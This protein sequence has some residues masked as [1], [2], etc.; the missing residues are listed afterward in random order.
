[1]QEP[2]DNQEPDDNQEP[3]D[4]QGSGENQ[5]SG[6]PEWYRIRDIGRIDSP[7]LVVY[8]A[9]VRENIR[10][11]IAMVGGDLSRLRPHVKTHKSPDLTRMMLD[12]GIHKFKCATIAEAEMLAACGAKDVLLAYQ[13]VGPKLERFI[14][15]VSTYPSAGFSCLFDDPEAAE[16]MDQA[17]V[18]NDLRI[19]AYLD[20]DLGMHRTGIPPG[21]QAVLLFQRFMASS[22]GRAGTTSHRGNG[23]N[24][25]IPVGLHAY[26]GHIREVDYDRRKEACDRAFAPVLDMQQ[27]ISRLVT[28]GGTVSRGVPVVAGGTPTFSIHGLRRGVECSPGTFVYW[29]KGYQEQCPEQGFLPAALV[30]TRVVSLPGDTRICLDLGHKSIAAENELSR[31]V[32]F[33]NAPVP[34]TPVAQSEEHLVVDAGSGR[35]LLHAGDV[36]YGLPFHICPTVALYERAL[37]VDNGLLTGEWSNQARDRRLR[38]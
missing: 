15:L 32:S 12:S 3:K 5:A 36:L 19:H 37:T 13:P 26:D 27:A 6:N 38:V 33:L 20:L 31:R 24:G 29:D 16:C 34:L 28:D 9:R 8:P 4:N 2:N 22:L 18:A 1:M 21:E 10:T 35:H 30:V 14:S 23:T 25:L 11:A 7:A 17:F